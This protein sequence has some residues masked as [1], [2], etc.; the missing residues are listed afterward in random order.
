M[1]GL[2]EA[3]DRQA[4]FEASSPEAFIEAVK[5]IEAK[6]SSLARV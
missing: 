6:I 4:L 5:A 1:Q 3:P 2:K